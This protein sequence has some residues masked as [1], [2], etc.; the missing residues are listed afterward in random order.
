MTKTKTSIKYLALGNS[1]LK[2]F[3]FNQAI[4][5]YKSAAKFLIAK[6][7]KYWP[8]RKWPEKCFIVSRDYHF[9]Y[10][11]IPKVAST[12]FISLVMALHNIDEQ[13]VLQEVGPYRIHYHITKKFSLSQYNHQEALSIINDP[14]YFKFVI[15]RNPWI[16]LASAYLDKFVQA[17]DLQLFAQEV[18]DKVYQRQGQTPNYQQSITFRQFLNYLQIT[19]DRY[20]DHHWLPQYL[21]LGSIKFDFVGKVE[22]LDE[23]FKY[24]RKRLKINLSLPNNKNRI[25]YS[26]LDD[27]ENYADY[28]PSQLKEAVT[29]PKYHQLYTPELAEIV[30]LRYREDIETFGY[31]F[32]S[33]SNNN[34]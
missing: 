33:D 13:K 16:R 6:A 3:Q 15:V 5:H 7:I 20:L 22:S 28:Y 25:P 27:L 23:D 21:F 29:L 18:I 34:N 30:K 31:D 2:E 26:K 9:V 4:N 10:S 8:Q 11:P 12:S 17:D 1:C 14:N 32:S 19:E 24:L